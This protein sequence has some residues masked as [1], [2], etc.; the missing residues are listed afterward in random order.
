MTQKE[1]NN[2]E[3]HL[4][5]DDGCRVCDEWFEQERRK[6]LLDMMKRV[7][8]LLYPLFETPPQCIRGLGD[9]PNIPP[10]RQNVDNL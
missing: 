5:A 10:D 6:E 9:N 7:K 8:G 1:F 2:H 4:S 3:C